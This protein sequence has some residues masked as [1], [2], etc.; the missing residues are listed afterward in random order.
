[1]SEKFNLK[2][3]DFQSNVSKS[4][5]LYKN[6]SY[7]QDV[8]LVSEDFKHIPAHKLVLSACSEY[9][10]RLFQETKQSQPL[11]CLDGVNA[12]D[13]KN[14]LD[15]VYDGEVKILQEDLHRFLNVAQ[16][17]KLEGL[18]RNSEQESESAVSKLEHQNESNPVWNS[19]KEEPKTYQNLPEQKAQR[20]V[21][22]KAPTHADPSCPVSGVCGQRQGLL[23]RHPEHEL[24]CG[25]QSVA[26]HES[27]LVLH[28]LTRHREA[29]S[30]MVQRQ[31]LTPDNQKIVCFRTME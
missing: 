20:N 18:I 9:F 3:N 31:V 15:Y 6:E 30:G 10:K 1:M 4:F 14:V 25:V 17:L 28:I 29:V 27:Q 23:Q 16:K 24:V 8:T 2:W 21:E 11:I 5:G 22:T 19:L 13:L 26:P 7:L 12:I